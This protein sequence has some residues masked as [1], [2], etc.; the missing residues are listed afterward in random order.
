MKLIIGDVRIVRFEENNFYF[1]VKLFKSFFSIFKHE[2]FSFF[3]L[4]TY[5]NKKF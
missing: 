5:I 1:H 4:Q 2:I 3:T